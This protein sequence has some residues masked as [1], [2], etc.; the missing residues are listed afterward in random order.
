MQPLLGVQSAID[1]RT[2]QF[3]E[4]LQREEAL[5]R[6]VHPS[7]RA[8]LEEEQR[9]DA[10]IGATGAFGDPTRKT[11]EGLQRTIFEWRDEDDTIAAVQAEEDARSAAKNAA[12]ELAQSGDQTSAA[13]E[14]ETIVDSEH[15][16]TP[17]SGAAARPKKESALLASRQLPE[18]VVKTSKQRV[19]RFI[20]TS[21]APS[22]QPYQVKKAADKRAKN[23]SN[24]SA[25][26]A[27][28]KGGGL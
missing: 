4:R 12:Q 13:E 1:P 6:E 18:T 26:T 14:A 22:R 25:R 7:S 28:V 21:T 19:Y 8:E 27:V 10:G 3:S 17:R 16:P 2:R 5:S 23:S 9:W 11:N 15:F 20:D 24:R